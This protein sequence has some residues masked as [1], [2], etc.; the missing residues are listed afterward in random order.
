MGAR[1][2]HQFPITSGAHKVL[3]CTDCHIVPQTFS[4]FSCID[5]HEHRQSEMDDK[6]DEVLNYVWETMA[7]Y[8]CQ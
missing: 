5:C 8:A 4:I 1:F 6:H 7:C 2:N 3:N